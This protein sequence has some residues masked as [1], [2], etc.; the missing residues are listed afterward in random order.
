M[1]VRWQVPPV[2]VKEH[3]C[4]P[5]QLK[6]RSRRQVCRSRSLLGN[7][8]HCIN[9]KP[10]H[11]WAQLA[12]GDQANVGAHQRQ[13]AA[14]QGGCGSWAGPTW[15]PACGGGQTTMDMTSH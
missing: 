14:L 7:G 2:N 12:G 4:T 10:S 8:P 15:K 13:Q 1:R 11:L 5:Y 6:A 3:E 9:N